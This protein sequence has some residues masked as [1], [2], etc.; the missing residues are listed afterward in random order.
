[1]FSRM[2]S[3][4]FEAGKGHTIGPGHYEIKTTMRDSATAIAGPDRWMEDS[5]VTPGPGYYERCPSVEH[6]DVP[7]KMQPKTPRC[8]DVVAKTPRAGSGVR[9]KENRAP[10]RVATPKRSKGSVLSEAEVERMKRRLEQEERR[11]AKAESRLRELECMLDASARESE[12]RPLESRILNSQDST[13][14]LQLDVKP[15]RLL[16]GSKSDGGSSQDDQENSCARCTEMEANI[17]LA[18]VEAAIELQETQRQHAETVKQQDE[19]NTEHLSE[20]QTTQSALV[21]ATGQLGT[22][23]EELATRASEVNEVRH[24]LAGTMEKLED[25]QRQV[26]EQAS[27]LQQ[28]SADADASAA[29]TQTLVS[30]LQTSEAKVLE[31]SELLGLQ[32]EESSAKDTELQELRK[33]RNG[34]QD[35]CKCLTDQISEM[36]REVCERTAEVAELRA[37]VDH[38]E[39]KAVKQAKEMDQQASEMQKSRA[40]HGMLWKELNSSKELVKNQTTELER[41]A[42]EYAIKSAECARLQAQLT[43]V[44][45]R[46]VQLQLKTTMQDALVE[47]G[48]E[49]RQLLDRQTADLKDLRMR[50]ATLEDARLRSS[51]THAELSTEHSELRRLLTQ[52]ST[53]VAELEAAKFIMETGLTVSREAIAARDQ[54]LQTE[55]EACKRAQAESLRLELLSERATAEA[56]EG[57]VGHHWLRMVGEILH[58]DRDRSVSVRDRIRRSDSSVTRDCPLSSSQA[59]PSQTEDGALVSAVVQRIVVS[60]L[61]R[62]ISCSQEKACDAVAD[63]GVQLQTSLPRTV[64]EAGVGALWCKQQELRNELE[65]A[66]AEIAELKRE[67]E[68]SQFSV[69]RPTEGSHCLAYRAEDEDNGAMDSELEAQRQQNRELMLSMKQF[70]SDLQLLT[71]ENENM[72]GTVAIFEGNLSRATEDRAR[73]IGHSNPK[74]K[75][76]YTMRLKEES[77]LLRDELKKSRKRIVQLE[78]GRRDEHHWDTFSGASKTGNVETSILGSDLDDAECHNI[79]VLR[80]RCQAQEMSVERISGNLH[81]VMALVERAVSLGAYADGESSISGV[82]GNFSELLDRLRN[83][84]VVPSQGHAFAGEHQ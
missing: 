43:E 61:R 26:E 3:D 5:F 77:N 38:M 28:K 46:V 62:R 80:R 1:M 82:P 47:S 21:Q 11:R 39:E 50:A 57:F 65:A 36:T 22:L 67:K 56:R 37:N 72:R 60:C 13:C 31:L 44:Q 63:G 29:E 53:K 64:V 40:N 6:F 4:R 9:S 45:A 17:E 48:E 25:A 27:Q 10:D 2:T 15:S 76:H 68:M 42:S 34:M 54:E 75:I 71:L 16:F 8:S 66:R 73:L 81:H 83:M 52:K 79:A 33:V 30:R 55:R 18:R 78:A 49:Q 35:A 32:V 19:K 20:L 14:D 84:A 12:S 69:G 58:V 74:Q 7:S 41:Q 23:E 70:H 59:L 51:T 24:Q